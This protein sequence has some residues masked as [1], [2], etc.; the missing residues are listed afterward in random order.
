MMMVMV[1]LLLLS[2]LYLA[3]SQGCS[4]SRAGLLWSARELDRLLAC[5]VRGT[6]PGASPAMGSCHALLIFNLSNLAC[7]AK[8]MGNLMLLG[9]TRTSKRQIYALI[10]TSKM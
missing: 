7:H 2:S 3:Y 1:W 8:V 6:R 10:E 4:R 5:H 9:I